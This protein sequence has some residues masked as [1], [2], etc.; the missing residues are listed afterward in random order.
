MHELGQRQKNA[1][2]GFWYVGLGLKKKKKMGG[3]GRLVVSGGKNVGN[4]ILTIYQE[5]QHES[6]N[7]AV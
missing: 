4:V 1:E 6:P 7:A 2:L 3:L 5:E